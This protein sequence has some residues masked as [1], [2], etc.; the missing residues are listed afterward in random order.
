MSDDFRIVGFV[1]CVFMAGFGCGVWFWAR[2]CWYEAQRRQREHE[3][4]AAM[5]YPVNTEPTD[6]Y[7]G[8]RFD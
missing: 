1:F 3:R 2:Q 5:F 4:R 6:P 8:P 7:G